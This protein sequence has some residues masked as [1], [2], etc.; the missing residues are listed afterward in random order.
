MKLMMLGHPQSVET[1]AKIG[2]GV[3]RGWQRRRA[4]LLAQESCLYEWKNIL[5]EASRKGYAGEDVLQWD[6]YR[7][8]A[9]QLEQ[10]W[11]ECIEKRKS[12]ARPKGSKRAPKTLEQRKKISEA[13]SAKWADPEYRDRIRAALAKY[14]GSATGAKRASRR[15]LTSDN[16]VKKDSVKISVQKDQV[17]CELKIHKPMTSRRRNNTSPSYKDPMASANLELLTKIKAERDALETK[18]REAIMRAKLLISEAERAAKALEVAALKSPLAKASLLETRRLIAEATCS[19]E[20]IEHGQ[21]MMNETESDSDR[22]IHGSQTVLSM[23]SE[24]QSDHLIANGSHVLSSNGKS[25]DGFELNQCADNF[26]MNGSD[27][28]Y[29]EEGGLQKNLHH[30]SNVIKATSQKS[31]D[32]EKV[33]TRR[34]KWVCGRLVEVED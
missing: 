23:M 9:E 6:S 29:W 10:E 1:K 11:L 5:A 14:Y 34:K 2:L 21:L 3:R 8:I 18:K 26:L 17:A 4:K 15:K 22:P 16:I 20:S 19:I 28:M 12:A 25:C 27:G 24:T 13:I 33:R 32:S 31:S 30:E 7:I